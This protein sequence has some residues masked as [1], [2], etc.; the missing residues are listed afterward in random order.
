MQEAETK[1]TEE[2][3]AYVFHRVQ[4][5]VRTLRK[6]PAVFCRQQASSWPDVVREFSD[7]WHSTLTHEATMPRSVPTHR[8]VSE[9]DEVLG[10]MVWLASQDRRYTRIVWLRANGASFGR[11]ARHFDKGKTWA[12]SQ[13]LN[14]LYLLADRYAKK[15]VA[16]ENGL[17]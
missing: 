9:M 3:M 12:H 8:Q 13:F 14:A 1:V 11:I 2:Q 4:G 6:M 15:V 16:K 10:W 7:I 5:A 17:R